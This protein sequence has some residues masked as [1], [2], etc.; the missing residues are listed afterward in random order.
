M[1]MFFPELHE[2]ATN[3]T[4]FPDDLFSLL[5][6][7]F[8]GSDLLAK[9]WM[10]ATNRLQRNRHDLMA[11]QGELF[12]MPLAIANAFHQWQFI[13]QSRA[14]DVAKNIL[15]SRQPFAPSPESRFRSIT[16]FASA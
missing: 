6:P 9:Y 11:V 8:P 7:V 15:A 16:P 1:V 2:V 4:Y 14:I 10:L 5:D 12:S 3:H 13:Q